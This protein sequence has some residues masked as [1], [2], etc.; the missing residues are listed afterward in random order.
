MKATIKPLALKP[1]SRSRLG[2]HIHESGV[3][4]KGEYES[5]PAPYGTVRL[6]G[7]LVPLLLQLKGVEV[8][9]HRCTL[10]TRQ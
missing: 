5:P 9:E 4:W 8:V 6:L 3:M 1:T 10:L 2:R 7:E